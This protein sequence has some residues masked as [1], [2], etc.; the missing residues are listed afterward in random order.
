MEGRLHVIISH[1]KHFILLCELLNV[2][3]KDLDLFLE[4]QHSLHLVLVRV[5]SR[6]VRTYHNR[7]QGL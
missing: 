5:H 7:G 2:A 4:P 1:L 3:I 6:V